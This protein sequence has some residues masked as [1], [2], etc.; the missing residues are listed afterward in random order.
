MDGDFRPDQLSPQQRGPRLRSYQLRCIKALARAYEDYNA[1]ILQ[2]ATAAG[3]TVIFS[4]LI[5]RLAGL[6]VLVLVLVHRRE[7]IKQASRK[8]ADAGVEHGVIA[9]GFAP[10]PSAAVQIGSIQTLVRRLDAL[11]EYRRR[12]LYTGVTRARSS[13]TIMRPPR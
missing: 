3:K 9:A 11:P 13:V 1:V 7:L 6:L 4:E 8:L 10:N 12:W 5:R 2:L